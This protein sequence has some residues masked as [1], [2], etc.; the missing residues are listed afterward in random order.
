MGNVLGLADNGITD[1]GIGAGTG[2]ESNAVEE[3]LRH[4]ETYAAIN[5]NK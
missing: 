1:N 5:I 4:M 2:H 3:V